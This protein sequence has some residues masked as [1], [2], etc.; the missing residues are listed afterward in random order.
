MQGRGFLAGFDYAGERCV[1]NDVVG[2]R[3]ELKDL[4]GLPREA[5]ALLLSRTS[6]G[7]YCFFTLCCIV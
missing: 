7:L 5:A 3:R 2:N 4:D 1:V 6:I